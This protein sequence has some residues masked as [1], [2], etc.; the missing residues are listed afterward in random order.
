MRPKITKRYTAAARIGER[1]DWNY[2]N[3][4][5]MMISR[6]SNAIVSHRSA[7]SSALIGKGRGN[8]LLRL[9][10]IVGNQ[11][12]GRLIQ[13][14]LKV[15]QPGD[16]S[17]READRVAEHVMRMA[18]TQLPNIES[19]AECAPGM[20]I[21][22]Q[23]ADCEEELQRQVDENDEAIQSAGQEVF[24][25]EELR[26]DRE[27]ENRIIAQGVQLKSNG[28]I[29]DPPESLVSHLKSGRSSG[30]PLPKETRQFMEER[31]NAPLGNVRIHTSSDAQ[32]MCAS[33]NAKAFTYGRNLYFAAGQ[34]QPKS[35]SGKTLIAHELVH[36]MQ[37][38]STHGDPGIQ[39]AC[40][41]FP[42]RPAPHNTLCETQAEA[43]ALPNNHACPPDRGDFV[44]RDGPVTHRW[45][46]I[47][48][49]ACA[50]YVAHRL[51]ITEGPSYAKCRGGFSVTITQITEGKTAHPLSAA[52]VNDIWSSGVH[53]GVVI[54]VDAAQNRVRVNQCNT[55]GSVQ[56]IWLTT[57]SVYR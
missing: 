10:P 27:E 37:Q 26:Q 52:H 17:E 12:V 16:P 5:K 31:L 7:E 40:Q 56:P 3:M 25:P 30:R 51:G 2:G 22:R 36:V 29:V 1:R 44:Y 50:H 14:K 13:A 39:R 55:A 24:T 42:D 4:Q 15:S 48:G 57:G 21:Q 49:Y 35:N 38:A 23:C 11:A 47:P 8:S 9:Q 43:A 34:F 32:G 33:L 46:P 53:S 54:Q 20:E 6:K 19:S 18:D 45:R 28:P 41:V